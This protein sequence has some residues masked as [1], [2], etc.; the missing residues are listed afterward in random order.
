MTYECRQTRLSL[1][2][3]RPEVAAF[4]GMVDVGSDAAGLDMVQLSI[5]NLFVTAFAAC[6]SD[7][8]VIA[9]RLKKNQSK[10]YGIFMP[11]RVL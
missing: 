3:R 8:A 6:V 1:W 7:D 11:V 10:F 5:V 4:R 9:K 2:Q